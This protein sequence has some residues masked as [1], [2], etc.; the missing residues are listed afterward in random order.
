ML[1][2]V[3]QMG[4]SPPSLMPAQ[5]IANWHHVCCINATCFF[6]LGIL[7][8]VFPA[9]SCRGIGE[10]VRYLPDEKQTKF[11][12]ALKLSLLRR[13]CPKSART[14]AQ[15][16]NRFTFG[17]V[18]AQHVT[19]AK[20]PIRVNPIFGRSLDWNQIIIRSHLQVYRSVSYSRCYNEQA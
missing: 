19:A 1:I 12:S 11:R 9:V 2:V 10:I 18:I 14:D 20:L 15:H 5:S 16:P 13:S 6:S 4:Q 3:W 17:G 7:Y 8:S